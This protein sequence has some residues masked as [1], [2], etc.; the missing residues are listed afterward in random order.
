MG[1]F[2]DAKEYLKTV[3]PTAEKM[4]RGYGFDSSVC[5]GCPNKRTETAGDPCSLCG[6][7]TV[8]GLLMDR[9]GQPPRDCPRVERHKE[10]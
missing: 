4:P 7:P 3:D 1:L 2:D 10:K 8:P 6:C 9:L 5:N